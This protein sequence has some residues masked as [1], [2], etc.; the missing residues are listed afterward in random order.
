M[1][2]EEKKPEKKKRVNSKAKGSGNELKIAK[3]LTEA[4]P[5]LNFKRIGCDCRWKECI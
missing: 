1:K 5:P 3:I 2:T 4:L